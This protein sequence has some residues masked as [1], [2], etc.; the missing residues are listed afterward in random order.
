M[1]I[2]INDTEFEGLKIIRPHIFNDE[3]GIY[4]KCYESEIFKQNGIFDIFNETSDL[5]SKKGALRGLHYQEKESQSKLLHVIS[6]T[7]YDVA[8]DLRKDS[9][10]FGK[11]FE[12]LLKD[13]DEKVIYI[14][15]GFAHGF[16]TLS[17]SAVFSYQC[18]GQY[19]PE[20]CG[21]ILWNDKKLN[22]NWPLKEYGIDKVI[23]TEKDSNW[24]TFDD[25][26]RMKKYE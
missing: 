5:T 3:R 15:K 6:G 13:E 10:T 1:P 8:L 22:I 11:C 24:P 18:S 4:K 19:I 12:I 23:C 25:Y 16:I 9:K 21:G 14:P 26:C 2:E 17:E 20:L 7:I